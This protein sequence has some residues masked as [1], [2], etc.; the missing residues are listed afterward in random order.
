[1]KKRSLRI[2]QLQAGVIFGVFFCLLWRVLEFCAAA[3]LTVFLTPL[4]S[5]AFYACARDLLPRVSKRTEF[6]AY[7]LIFV[8]FVICCETQAL[9][10]YKW[11]VLSLHWFLWGLHV[12]HD[13]YS[14]FVGRVEALK[15]KPSS[16]FPE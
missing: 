5:P 11:G 7:I 2:W 12:G 9:V 8:A 4:W 10:A 3:W 6:F 16:V 1:M 15:R 13:I 14:F